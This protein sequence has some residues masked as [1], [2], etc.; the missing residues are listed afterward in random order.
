MRAEAAGFAEPGDEIGTG[1]AA[2]L[3]INHS[4]M[5]LASGSARSL[6]TVILH[7]DSRS[8]YKHGND[9]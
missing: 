2:S 5:N 6:L 9:S 4:E 1:Q 8:D 7:A 3:V